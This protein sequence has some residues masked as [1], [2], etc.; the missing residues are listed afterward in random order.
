MLPYKLYLFVN[1]LLIGHV[2]YKYPADIYLEP[3][4]RNG[5][6]GSIVWSI[7]IRPSSSSP[8]TLR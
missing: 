3:S 7:G 2:T 8:S 6:I 1:H 4:I 5:R